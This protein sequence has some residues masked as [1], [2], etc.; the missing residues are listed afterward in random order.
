[1]CTGILA[2]SC[3]NLSP[4]LKG[5][6]SIYLVF[7]ESASHAVQFKRH[8]QILQIILSVNTITVGN[9]FIVTLRGQQSSA[10]DDVIVYMCIYL[11]INA[12]A[13]Q[14]PEEKTASPP[15]QQSQ[16]LFLHFCSSLM[17]CIC[18]CKYLITYIIIFAHCILCY[19]ILRFVRT[20]CLQPNET[21]LL[22]TNSFGLSLA[23]NKITVI[24]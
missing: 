3:T 17:C 20:Q 24:S 19:K 11:H 9:D 2:T 21:L 10:G 15:F 18:R 23:I 14:Q 22:K 16:L 7:L 12:R 4:T 13:Q 5:G 1:M 8:L 6:A